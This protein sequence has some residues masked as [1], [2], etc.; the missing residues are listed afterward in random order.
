LDYGRAMKGLSEM[1]ARIVA[2]LHARQDAMVSTVL[3]WAEINSGSRNMAGLAAMAARL[4]A[5]IDPLADEIALLP[6]A[7]V[8]TLGDDG[9][10]VAVPHGDILVASKRCEAKRR[11]ILT[12][13]MDT[14]FAIDDPFQRC[15]MIDPQTLNG[16][17]TADM[18][19]GLLVMIEAL[20]ALEATGFPEEIGWDV[21]INGDEEVGSLGS[22]HILRD[23]ARRCQFGLTF[24]PS[25]T[26]EGRLS[27]A[28][29]GSGNFVAH[30]AGRPAHAG[31]NPQDGRNAV[32]AAADMAL[33]LAALGGEIAGLSVNVARVGGGGPNNVVPDSAVL[34]WNMRPADIAAQRA[35][36]AAIT[37]ICA[38]IAA[39]HGI[40]LSLSG[41]F[42]RP[43]KPFDARHA[44]LFGLVREA[45]ADLGLA[46]DWAPS[47]GVCDG[48]NIAAEG[49]AVV[50][51]MG[52]RGGAIH[53][54]EEFLVLPSLSER[55]A[56]AAITLRRLAEGRLAQ[57]W[58]T[59]SAPVV[60][61]HG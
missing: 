7:P 61:D 12:G 23:V 34:A 45:G 47:G 9:R 16:P 8:M 25:Q 57:G 10:E 42:A 19:G 1:E 30:F 6:A 35:A 36:E 26:P 32:V 40:A 27:S 31:R 51:T 33:R 20:S 17:G 24:E 5:H 55:A 60:A 14:V 56:L 58:K 28:R 11:I 22:A 50:D 38:E 15:R 21:V 49:V 3:G 53:T 29:K 44:E 18:K 52:V 4:Q 2:A 46:I 48:N 39:A 54:S 59:A 43:P 37:R 41:H 13:H